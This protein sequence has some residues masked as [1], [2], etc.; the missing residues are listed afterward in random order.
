MYRLGLILR[1]EN[2]PP[3]VFGIPAPYERSTPVLSPHFVG[4]GEARQTNLI[5]SP[6][7]P[8]P[9]RPTHLPLKAQSPSLAPCSPTERSPLD[10]GHFSLKPSTQFGNNV[11]CQGLTGVIRDYEGLKGVIR[12]YQG[13]SGVVRGYQGLSGVIRDCLSLKVYG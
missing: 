7:L 12:D 8:P 1:V 13:L 6:P 2:E 9:P 3:S 10:W 5:H 11:T 4:V